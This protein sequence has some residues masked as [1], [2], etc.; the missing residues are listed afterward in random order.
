MGLQGVVG[1]DTLKRGARVAQNPENIHAQHEKNP[2]SVAEAE[3]LENEDDQGFWDQ[4]KYLKV[5]VPL[6]GSNKNFSLT[7]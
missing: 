3:A 2:L 6:S 5:G 7:Q 1:V 4:T